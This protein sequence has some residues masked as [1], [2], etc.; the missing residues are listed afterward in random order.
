LSDEIYLQRRKLTFAQAEGVD[1]LP[2]QMERGKISQELSALVWNVIYYDLRRNM[3]HSHVGFHW[4]DI[5]Q[6]YHVCYLHKP[7]DEFEGFHTI[8]YENLKEII[9]SNNYISLFGFLQFV[10]RHPQCPPDLPDSISSCLRNARAAYRLVNKDTF[11]PIV[12]EIEAESVERAFADVTD[13]NLA[14]A[15]VHLRNAAECLTVGSYTDAIRE[16]VHAVESAARTLAPSNSLSDALAALEKKT[17]IHAGL[18]RGFKAIYGYTSDEEG[19]RHSLL[20]KG[21]ASVDE[22]DALFMFSACAAFIS[23][24]LG[25]ARGAGILSSGKDAN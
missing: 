15:H 19:I 14:G 25:K 5:L 20:D 6:D 10:L 12:S 8:V 23:Y 16:S 4:G 11:I 22:T 13:G 18:K 7:I 9:F 24:L 1:P 17:P 2:S 21:S 3:E